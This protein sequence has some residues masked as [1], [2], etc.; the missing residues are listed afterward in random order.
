MV[1]CVIT[2]VQKKCN[3]QVIKVITVNKVIKMIMKC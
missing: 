3:S 1:N 2:A